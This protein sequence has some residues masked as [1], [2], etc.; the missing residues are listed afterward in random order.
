M[1][2]GKL[3]RVRLVRDRI[4]P[5]YI[6]PDHGDW[7]EIA[8]QLIDVFKDAP[9]RTRGELD[10]DLQ[11]L[12]G[13]GAGQLVHAGFAKLLDDRCE[14]DVTADHDPAEVR[15]RVFSL[16]ATHRKLAAQTGVAFDR[17][18]V[19]RQVASDLDLTPEQVDHSLF[20]D[21]KDEQRIVSFKPLSAEQLVHRYNV[22]LVQGILVRSSAVEMRVWGETPARLRQLF[23]AIKF[24]RL[25]ATIT[26]E[27]PSTW[28]IRLDGPLSLFSS[29]QKYGLQ[30][31]LFVPTL[32]HCKAFELTAD[33]HWGSQRKAKKFSFS[34]NDGLRSH[35][36]DFGVY[37]PPEF[38]LFMENFQA[39]AT[40]WDISDEPQ[41]MVFPDGVWVP[42]FRLLHHATGTEIYLEIFG[43]WRKADIDAH[44]QRLRKRLPGRFIVAVSDQ[45]H[46]EE[47]KSDYEA[48]EVYRYKRTPSAAAIA[49]LATTLAR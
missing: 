8:Q 40:G 45:Y 15:D 2:T 43:Y 46:A 27:S 33:I 38:K 13:E 29:T 30:L 1:L 14:V 12:L 4:I 9:G 34:A 37:T 11:A 19:L 3:I 18:T 10:E 25:I 36:P 47:S 42:D 22:G 39:T 20:A 31:A 23:R 44:T 16:A 24:H 28:I 21:L 7:L 32:L 49:K 17:G 5:V 26:Q 48:H 35:L 6:D 41:P